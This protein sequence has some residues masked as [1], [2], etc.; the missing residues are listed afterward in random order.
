MTSIG[1]ACDRR[2]GRCFPVMR[3]RGRPPFALD[4]ST[5]WP[6][7]RWKNIGPTGQADP[8]REWS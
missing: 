7:G 1:R 4:T 5:G 6:P 8:S 2:N 3:A